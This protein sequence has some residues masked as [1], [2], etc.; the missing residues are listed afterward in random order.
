MQERALTEH[1]RGDILNLQ[2]I[3]VKQWDIKNSLQIKSQAEI[4]E[5]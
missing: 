1:N 4:N 2:E 3:L 5:L